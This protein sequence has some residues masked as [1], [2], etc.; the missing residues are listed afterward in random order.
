MGARV[1]A[2][3]TAADRDGYAAL[4]EWATALGPIA[5]FAVEGT[6]SYGAGLASYLRRQTMRVVEVSGVD[7]RKRRRDG[8]DDTLD[9]ESAARSLLAGTSTA[10]PKTADGVSEMVRQLKIARDTR[11]EGSPRGYDCA[12]D[13]ARER[14]R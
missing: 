1:A 2:C 11:R 3:R 5:G 8:K 12:Q 6:G 13:A 9:A 10:V 7:R 4:L 14:P